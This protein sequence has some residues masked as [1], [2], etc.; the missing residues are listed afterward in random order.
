MLT[1][2]GIHVLDTLCHDKKTKRKTRRWPL[3]YF[4]GVLHIVAVNILVLAKWNSG[5]DEFTSQA[6][7]NFLKK[8][9]LALVTPQM[10][11]RLLNPHIGRTLR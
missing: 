8:L 11:K 3:R 10:E 2:G 5:Q 6:R 9:Y 7:N 4:F 1:K